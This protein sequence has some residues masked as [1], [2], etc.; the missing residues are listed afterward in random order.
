[1]DANN[2][3][4]TDADFPE[5]MEFS[6]FLPVHSRHAP[7]VANN[8]YY[9]IEWETG[10]VHCYEVETKKLIWKKL[11]S[12]F[13]NAKQAADL[14]MGNCIAFSETSNR[15]ILL[16]TI[17]GDWWR[18]KDFVSKVYAL[19]P[20][21][22][23]IFWEETING[24][25]ANS[26]TVYEKSLFVKVIDIQRDRASNYL[27]HGHKIFCISSESGHVYWNT[28]MLLGGEE[29]WDYG[30]PA[31]SEK[32]VISTSSNCVYHDTSENVIWHHNPCYVNVTN[33]SNGRLITTITMKGFVGASMPFIHG[34][35]VFVITTIS[36]IT[37]HNYLFCYQI[38]ND[39]AKLLKKE[40]LSDE[41]HSYVYNVN[42]SYHGKCIYYLDYSGLLICLSVATLEIQWKKKVG[43]RS[44]MG[45]YFCNDQYLI[46]C[47]KYSFDSGDPI[48]LVYEYISLQY[49]DPL[50]GKILFNNPVVFEGGAP[51]E[52][53]CTNNNIWAKC[54]GKIAH[55]T[56]APP[57]Q[58]EVHPLEISETCMEGDTT[59]IKREILI[60]T[61]GHVQG[62]IHCSQDWIKLPRSVIQENSENI[63]ILIDPNNLNVGTHQANIYFE[64]NG[65]N[66]TVMV[67]LDILEYPELTVI[68]ERIDL[69]IP[70]GTNPRDSLFYIDNI[71][72]KGLQGTI[73][74]SE[75]WI[76]ISD[77]TVDDKLKEFTSSYDMKHFEPGLYKGE[78]L[79]QTNGGNKTIPIHITITPKPFLVV[80]PLHV[81][82]EVAIGSSES[83]TLTLKNTGGKGLFGTI[84]SDQDWL[85]P[86]QNLYKD[87]TT[88]IF[89]VLSARDLKAGTYHGNVT[90]TGNDQTIVVDVTLKCI[91][92]ITFQIG[93]TTVE[94][95]KV[96]ETI[97]APPYLFQ[98]RSF[99][100]VRKLV[101]SLPVLNYLKNAEMK[102]D[103]KERKVTIIVGDKTTELW[104]DQST[105]KVNG[106]ETPIDPDNSNITPQIREGRTFL[107]LRFVSETLGY[108]VEWVGSTQTIH[109]K[110]IVN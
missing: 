43:E 2:S 42:L 110:Y 76:H 35:K 27:S 62:T 65:G 93:S 102:W 79:I 95:N 20:E 75:D 4:Y 80:H 46:I 17:Q 78:I 22:G 61:E 23:S 26:V 53:T 44:W 30:T 34:D 37:L 51:S 105:A 19:H 52:L 59:L 9:L 89:L 92:W 94:V 16:E 104:V 108:Q 54:G 69:I 28:P 1:M 84:H 101:E 66:H 40:L 83:V 48:A 41:L 64:S 109:L 57:P 3:A 98:K 107:P 74:V 38:E 99:V 33:R 88:S 73:E 5:T 14:R 21:N 13:P 29:Y 82:K 63:N 18:K 97:S 86:S 25:Y 10:E 7:I 36:G 68:P 72:G 100:P 11:Y 8:H 91:V 85:T 106:V 60:K 71:G 103:S 15:L 70:E 90:F 24:F 45:P 49:I 96:K 6:G 77:K 87:D 58:L 47:T 50:T 56:P 67:T 32:Y 31:V 81:I 39:E 55:F 12:D